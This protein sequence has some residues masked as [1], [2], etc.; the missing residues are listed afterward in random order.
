MKDKCGYVNEKFPLY[1]LFDPPIIRQF[2]NHLLTG[3]DIKSL[4]RTI[5]DRID[6][7]NIGFGFGKSVDLCEFRFCEREKCE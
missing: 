7:R 4:V 5:N 3:V 2:S 6:E 1:E